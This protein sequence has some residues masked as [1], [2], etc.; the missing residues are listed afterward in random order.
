MLD[1]FTSAKPALFIKEGAQED[2]G[3]NIFL[4]AT[5]NNKAA[6]LQDAISSQG[7]ESRLYSVTKGP[8]TTTSCIDK[9]WVCCPGKDPYKLN[10]ECLNKT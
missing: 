7:L 1:C 5:I 3:R 4:E 10:H 6:V 8:A 2:Q 9:N